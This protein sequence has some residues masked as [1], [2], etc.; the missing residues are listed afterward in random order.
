M[1]GNGKRRESEENK[2]QQSDIV[3]KEA[4]QKKTSESDNVKNEL[5][6]I[7]VETNNKHN[8]KATF[9]DATKEPT[10]EQTVCL[11]KLYNIKEKY[12][13]KENKKFY[14]Q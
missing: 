13:K 10:M 14:E 7:E 8:V 12:K 3:Q 6:P 11:E 9:P 4:P 1:L 5:T 2:L